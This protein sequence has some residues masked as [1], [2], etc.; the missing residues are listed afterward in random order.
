MTAPCAASVATRVREGDWFVSRSEALAHSPIRLAEANRSLESNWK[1]VLEGPQDRP[2]M[3]LDEVQE[4]GIPQAQDTAWTLEDLKSRIENLG[5]RCNHRSDR[6]A[7]DIG[8]WQAAIVPDGPASWSAIVSMPIAESAISSVREALALLMLRASGTVRVARGFLAGSDA[9]FM[10]R[11]ATAC[12]EEAIAAGL[13][14]LSVCCRHFAKSV[15][16]LQNEEAAKA[17]L[18]FHTGLSSES[19]KGDHENA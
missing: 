19:Q 13:D 2:S 1:H 12:P 4:E 14:A 5:F 6:I 17:Y 9:G 16:V 18:A 15:S 7:V 3:R 11:F 10:A 8:Q